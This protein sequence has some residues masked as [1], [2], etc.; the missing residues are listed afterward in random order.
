MQKGRA[1]NDFHGGHAPI[2]IN[3]RVDPNIAGDMLVPRQGRINGR[4]RGNEFCLLYISA[5]GKG[6]DGSRRLFVVHRKTCV[7]RFRIGLG[8]RIIQDKSRVSFNGVLRVVVASHLGSRQANFPESRLLHWF[9][10]WCRLRRNCA[11]HRSP[12]VSRVRRG[13]RIARRRCR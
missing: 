8:L 5:N 7:K 2:G 3:E 11:G 4:N 12:D 1:G 6:H 13:L 9:R 10:S